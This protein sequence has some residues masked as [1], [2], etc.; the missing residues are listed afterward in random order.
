MMPV[1]SGLDTLFEILSA[2]H[3]AKMGMHSWEDLK[4]ELGSGLLLSWTRI[5]DW[6]S[7]ILYMKCEIFLPSN[8]R[9]GEWIL[10]SKAGQ[11]QRRLVQLLWAP[12]FLIKKF[13]YKDWPRWDWMP[14]MLSINLQMQTIILMAL[15][16]ENV[17]LKAEVIQSCQGTLT[18]AHV[19][20]WEGQAINQ[21]NV[22]TGSQTPGIWTFPL[23]ERAKELLLS[24]ICY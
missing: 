18:N 16:H 1:Y 17:I 10:S 22:T 6:N 15:P 11:N 20:W 7:R 19:S 8:Q 5:N 2:S 24:K 4:E 3:Q 14:L 23:V 21:A 13:I 12:G 9:C